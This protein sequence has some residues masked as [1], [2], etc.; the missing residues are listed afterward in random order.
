MEPAQEQYFDRYSESY[1]DELNDS[2]KITGYEGDHFLRSKLKKLRA[3]FGKRLN[4]P[5]NF[6]DFGCSAGQTAELISD[7]F[8]TAHYVG[9]DSSPAMIYEAKKRS[10]CDFFHRDEIG[11]KQKS[12]PLI[13]AA[14]VFHHIPPAQH[15]DYLKDLIDVL[16]PGGSL[17]IWEHNPFN[18]VTRK[19]VCDC[20]FDRDAIL[21][22]ARKMKSQLT[23]L[24][25]HPIQIRYAMFFPKCLSWLEPLE[26]RME[27]LP[28]G[29][30]YL[31]ILQA[32]D[33]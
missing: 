28:L 26:S 31:A 13:L 7:Y 4:D 1:S 17:V 19:I 29:A 24:T 11:W 15:S 2:I 33:S 18:P 25:S 5:F 23:S 10:A 32:P 16:T 14:N 8:P 9:V 22:S 20:V 6:L 27:W 30:Q 21:I 3:L 12:Y